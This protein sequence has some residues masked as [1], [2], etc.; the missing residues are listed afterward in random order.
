MDNPNFEVNSLD[1]LDVVLQYIQQ[2]RS[3]LKSEYDKLN[4]EREELRSEQEELKS[5]KNQLSQEEKRLILERET[6][7]KEKLIVAEKNLV[8][9]DLVRLNVGGKEFVTTRTTL[10]SVKG[11]MLEAMFSGRHQLQPGSDGRFFLDRNPDLFKRILQYLRD[12][13]LQLPSFDAKGKVTR[14]ALIS[15]FDYFCIPIM[16]TIK[17]KEARKLLEKNVIQSQVIDCFDWIWCLDVYQN[18]IF[19]GLR[20]KTIKMWDI[21]TGKSEKSLK[22]HRN[23]VKCLEIY[24]EIM[25]TA[26]EDPIIKLWNLQTLRNERTIL[27]NTIHI[28]TRRIIK[29]IHTTHHCLVSTFF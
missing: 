12:G 26:S 27:G 21:E 4:K 5:R 11:S 29:G 23:A 2:A 20:D 9:D 3:Y 8:T 10:T 22:A 14:Q 13:L 24:E 6:F 15:E 7:E 1:S 25:V 17:E 19:S 28:H 16:K 18:K